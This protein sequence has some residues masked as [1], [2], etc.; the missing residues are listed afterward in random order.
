[1]LCHLRGDIFAAAGGDRGVEQQLVREVL[2]D[3]GILLDKRRRRASGFRSDI[4][5][6]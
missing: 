4:L 2:V 3:G 1:V 5:P 6:A